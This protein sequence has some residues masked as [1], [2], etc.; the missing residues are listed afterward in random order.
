MI[1][2]YIFASAHLGLQLNQINN[3]SKKTTSNTTQKARQNN[4]ERQTEQKNNRTST[5][6]HIKNHHSKARFPK[7][8]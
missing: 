5:E 4:T 2:S 8:L 1:K 7:L 3:Y 6:Q